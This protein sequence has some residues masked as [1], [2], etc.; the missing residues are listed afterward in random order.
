MPKPFR[1]SPKH[2]AFLDFDVFSK[3]AARLMMVSNMNRRGP[4]QGLRLV[5]GAVHDP[6]AILSRVWNAIGKSIV[7]LK[8]LLL[9]IDCQKTLACLS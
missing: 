5:R 7:E 1:P 6:Q 2:E 4:F 9:D 8:S 3:N